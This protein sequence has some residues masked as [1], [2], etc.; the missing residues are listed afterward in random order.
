MI[1]DISPTLL[2]LLVEWYWQGMMTGGKSWTRVARALCDD[3]I[4]KH[5]H[6]ALVHVYHEDIAALQVLLET[7][8]TRIR[9]PNWKGMANMPEGYYAE[10]CE[11]PEEERVAMKLSGEE[12]FNA[13][14]YG[15]YTSTASK[16]Y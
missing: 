2:G 3:T 14:C 12:D 10:R 13:Y 16:V 15:F 8:P 11:L 4:F 1:N 6:L 9:S 7:W 5:Q